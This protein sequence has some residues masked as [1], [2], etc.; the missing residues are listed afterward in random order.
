MNVKDKNLKKRGPAS[1]SDN[2]R[3]IKDT[4]SHI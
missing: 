4:V 2:L 3:Y 1:L